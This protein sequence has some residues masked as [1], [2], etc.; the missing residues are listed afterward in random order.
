[1]VVKEV[2]MEQVGQLTGFR[3]HSIRIGVSDMGKL[4]LVAAEN[5]TSHDSRTPTLPSTKKQQLS[6]YSN[7]ITHDTFCTVWV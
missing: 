1:M 6:N 7:I 5:I 3:L 2:T 4:L